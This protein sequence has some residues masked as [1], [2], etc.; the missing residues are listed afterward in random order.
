[1]ASDFRAY[2][3]GIER[4]LARATKQAV[5][6]AT[7]GAKAVVRA[8][9]VAASGPRA[10]DLVDAEVF[11]AGDSANAAG[12][13]F[14]RGDLADDILQAMRT[15]PTI[16]PRGGGYLTIPLPAAQALRSGSRSGSAV[17]FSMRAL[18]AKFGRKNI[19]VVP[20]EGQADARLVLARA[21]RYGGRS[22]PWVPYFVLKKSVTYPQTLKGIEAE[23]QSLADAVPALIARNLGGG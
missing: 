13:I 2:A 16:T 9:L 20:I 1:M 18:I 21:G 8:R 23:I 3:E 19:R 11:P 15:G 10:G 6:T 12:S 17:R 4:E 7:L 22:A 5:T 14:A